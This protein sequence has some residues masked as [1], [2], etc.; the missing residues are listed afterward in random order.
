MWENNLSENSTFC[1]RHEAQA[2]TFRDIAGTP[3][4]EDGPASESRAL[5]VGDR[6]ECPFSLACDHV[7]FGGMVNLLCDQEI[8]V[9]SRENLASKATSIDCGSRA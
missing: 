7:R 2:V 3:I 4:E 8:V 5:D 6:D 1:F 9:A